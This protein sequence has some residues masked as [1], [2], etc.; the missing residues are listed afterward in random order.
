MNILVI[1]GTGF[2]GAHLAARLTRDGH[3]LTLPTRSR[4]RAR[5]LTV[6]PQVEVI[7]ADVQDEAGQAAALGAVMREAPTGPS[8]WRALESFG[9]WLGRRGLIAL[10]GG[11]PP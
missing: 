5:H 1:G 8:N 7:E 3:R 9:A 2:V 4:D 10:R 11:S 6:L